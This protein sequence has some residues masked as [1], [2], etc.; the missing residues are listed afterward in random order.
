MS[1]WCYDGGGESG[2][3]CGW[4]RGSVS[5]GVVRGVG[6][7]CGR[8]V[9]G[10]GVERRIYLCD[11]GVGDYCGYGWWVRWEGGGDVLWGGEC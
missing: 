11:C 1:C 3:V 9:E 5:V 8:V 7:V 10:G 2:R 4:G 6:V